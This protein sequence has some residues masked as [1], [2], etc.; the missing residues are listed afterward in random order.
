MNAN[1]VYDVFVSHS[2]EDKQV[3]IELVKHLRKDGLRV[4]VY[5]DEIQDQLMS[6]VISAGLN[7]SRLLLVA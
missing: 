7:A 4:W 1:F 6:E 5:E 2:D 3:V